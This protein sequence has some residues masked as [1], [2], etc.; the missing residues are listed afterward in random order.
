MMLY[1]FAGLIGVLIA[2]IGWFGFSSITLLV[3]GTIFYIVETILESKNLNAGARLVDIIIFG[4]GS[5]VSIVIK[6]PFYIGGLLAIN[7][8]SA[9]ITLLSAPVYIGEIKMFFKY[10]RK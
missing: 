10:F 2:L 9:L 7:F 5:I 1:F 6:I 8:Y 4:I 3:V